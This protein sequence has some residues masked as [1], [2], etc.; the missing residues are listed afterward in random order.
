MKRF[1]DLNLT[2]IVI[3][4]LLNIRQRKLSI[5][6][7]VIRALNLVNKTGLRD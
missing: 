4:K 1:T 2:K 6:E 3:K 5:Q 7:Y